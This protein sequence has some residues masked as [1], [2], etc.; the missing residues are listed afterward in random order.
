MISKVVILTAFDEA[1]K[2]CLQHVLGVS[3]ASGDAMGGAEDSVVMRLEKRFKRSRRI[4]NWS[5]GSYGLHNAL[6]IGL[7]LSK[8]GTGRAY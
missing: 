3:G 4:W 5:Q 8:R 7:P 1:E 2:N 6:L